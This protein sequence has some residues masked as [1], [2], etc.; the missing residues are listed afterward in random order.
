MA[1]SQPLDSLQRGDGLRSLFNTTKTWQLVDSRVSE[2]SCV[3]YSI[4]LWYE[5]R[6]AFGVTK[7]PVPPSQMFV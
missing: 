6:K 1:G 5:R 3:A 2:T 7:A 4:R